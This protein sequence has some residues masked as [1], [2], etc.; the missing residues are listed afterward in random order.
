MPAAAFLAPP[1]KP[2]RR[3]TGGND[4]YVDTVVGALR[5][6]LRQVSSETAEPLES[7]LGPA[8]AL[9]ERLV[10]VVPTPSRLAEVVGPVY[11]QATLAKQWGCSRQAVGDLVH[12]RRLLALTTSDRVVVIPAFQLDAGLRPLH[13]IADVLAILTEDIVDGWTLA[14]W[15]TAP[16]QRLGGHSVIEHLAANGDPGQVLA[17]A[18]AAR[19]RWSR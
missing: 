2:K 15:I 7:V 4:A 19:R 11:R 12:R 9:A 6:R 5:A 10:A 17:V 16:Q 13:G 1:K 14:S 18:E 3:E 8:D